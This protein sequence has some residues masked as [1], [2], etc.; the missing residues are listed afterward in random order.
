MQHAFRLTLA[1]AAVAVVAVAAGA[2]AQTEF[3]Q[4]RT[5]IMVMNL[6]HEV[7]VQQKGHYQGLAASAVVDL[8]RKRQ[9]LAAITKRMRD[10][11][12]DSVSLWP[13]IFDLYHRE[14]CN[15][16]RAEE[17]K[18]RSEVYRAEQRVRDYDSKVRLYGSK[19]RLLQMGLNREIGNY[20]AN[21]LLEAIMASTAQ[22]KA[23]APSTKRDIRA[24]G[25]GGK[26]RATTPSRTKTKA[27]TR[28]QTT[29]RK[30]RPPP[31]KG[32][33]VHDRFQSAARVLQ[34]QKALTGGGTRLR[35]R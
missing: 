25:A 22:D 26:V 8:T 6:R 13:T 11:E 3:E 5:N 27:P 35:T 4:Q 21:L 17:P 32:I 28:R 19:I 29:I 23:V 16:L 18:V 34:Q 2:R 14:E 1:A 30:T 31:K 7:A 10:I 33:R 24:P 12:C 15:R 20:F 9:E